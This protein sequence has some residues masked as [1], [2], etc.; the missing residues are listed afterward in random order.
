MIKYWICQNC[1]MILWLKCYHGI[2]W[3]RKG[4]GRELKR[5]E[6]QI[7]FRLSHQWSH[8]VS[9]ASYFL[10][11]S[12]NEWIS[13]V[14][15]ST[16]SSSFSLVD[17]WGF[18]F[19]SDIYVWGVQLDWYNLNSSFLSFQSPFHSSKKIFF[20][21]FLFFSYNY[22]ACIFNSLIVLSWKSAQSCEYT[23]LYLRRFS[24]DV[25]VKFVKF[26]KLMNFLKSQYL[27]CFW[28]LGF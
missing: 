24:I 2:I 4:K 15:F 14:R 20:F 3:W 5:E 16:N 8:P 13:L 12:M 6:D 7:Y 28:M 26:L 9:Q 11:L 25:F 18:W 27:R 22:L 1:L 23:I 21:Q 19:I 10:S 17:S